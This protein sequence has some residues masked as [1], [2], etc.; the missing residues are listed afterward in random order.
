MRDS[1]IGITAEMQL[2][3]LRP[4]RAGGPIARP[5][6][7]GTGIGLTL[8]RSLVELHGG[9]IGVFSAG[10]GLGSEFT[11]RLPAISVAAPA[12]TC[13]GPAQETFPS[14]PTRILIVDDNRDSVLTL[15]RVLELDGHKVHCLFDGLSVFDQVA[16]FKPDV[17][18]LD[19]GLPGLDGYQVAER[20]RE[21][22]SR[23]ELR[24]IAV[25]GYGGE[26]DHALAKIAGFDDY[27]IKPA[28]LD[29]ANDMLA[30][31]RISEGLAIQELRAR[32]RRSARKSG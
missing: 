30:A 21:S 7:R 10:P 1:G 25:T 8:V 13:D 22:F 27:L 20:L 26:R 29:R 31:A 3:H 9:S 2:K 6:A 12:K 23:Q 15:A 11:V 4:F 24:L 16:S 19:I 14:R 28:G 5:G 32:R 17:I 18:L